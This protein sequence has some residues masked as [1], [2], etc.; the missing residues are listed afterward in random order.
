LNQPDFQKIIKI[1]H[2]DNQFKNPEKYSD[3]IR[4]LN[5]KPEAKHLPSKITV[6]SGII[7]R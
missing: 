4:R 7:N 3:K 6:K 2:T 5:A 1:Q